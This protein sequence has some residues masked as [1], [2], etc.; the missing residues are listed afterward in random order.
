MSERKIILT[1][2]E[3]ILQTIPQIK[4]V[5]VNRISPVNPQKVDLPGAFI[6]SGP[7]VRD[8]SEYGDANWNWEILIEVW[9]KDSD[10]EDMLELVHATIYLEYLASE[11][12]NRLS[13]VGANLYSVDVADELRG[14]SIV[15]QINYNTP[16]EQV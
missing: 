8:K 9:A 11:F 15:Y 6:Y 14:L 5:E 16:V 3:S 12:V 13:R 4:T 2:F 1:K 10:M 7:E